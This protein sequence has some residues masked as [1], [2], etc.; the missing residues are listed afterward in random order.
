MDPNSELAE[1]NKLMR[2]YDSKLKTKR[3]KDFIRDFFNTECKRCMPLTEDELYIYRCLTGVIRIESK[4]ELAKQLGIKLNTLYKRITIIKSVLL[5][6]FSDVN[7]KRRY[8]K[9]VKSKYDNITIFDLG[10][11]FTGICNLRILKCYYLKDITLVSSELLRNEL[12]DNDLL[13]IQ[14]ALKDANMILDEKYYKPR[15]VLGLKRAK[16]SKIA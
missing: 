7:A 11:S 6:Y 9:S 14:F 1:L 10:L 4:K 8:N 12:S 3:N 16:I 5:S 13:I 15:K 2:K